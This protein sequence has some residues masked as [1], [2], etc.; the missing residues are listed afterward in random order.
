[1]PEDYP[2][3]LGPYVLLAPIGSGGMGEVWKARDTR[4]NRIVAIKRLKGQHASRF[5]QEARAIASLSHPNIC[6]LYDVGPDYLVMEYIEGK[7]VPGKLPQE[8]A[9]RFAIQIA[10]ALEEAHSRGILHR[11]LKPGNILISAKGSVKLLDFGLAKL[12]TEDDSDTTRTID[13]T[14]LGTA[15]YMSPEQAQGKRL[16][17]RSDVFSFGVV[18]YEMVSGTRAFSGD[19]LLETLNAVVRDEPAPLQSPAGDIVKRCMAKQPARRFQSIAEVRA[20][21]EQV[22]LKQE[23]RQPSIAVLPFANMSGD[24]EQEYFSEG[25]AEEII[26]ALT[27]VPGLKVIA[28][29]SAFA[30]KGKNEDIRRIAEALGV[31][32]ILEGSVRKAGNRIRVMA[33]LITAADG[34]HLWSER[35]DRDLT[36]IF[37]VQDEIAAA[38]AGAL[39]VTSTKST[40]L[41]RRRHAQASPAY[42]AYI[43]RARHYQWRTTPVSLARSKECYEQAIALDPKSALAYVDLATILRRVR[44]S[45][46]LD[47]RCRW[48]VRTP[49]KR[50]SLIPRCRKLTACRR[51]FGR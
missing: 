2:S 31:V 39:Q 37:A 6:V 7:P 5:E 49:R 47:R 1:M 44:I 24:K 51:E 10:S 46:R 26:N 38:I 22:L 9:I 36:D 4:L 14:V 41:Q 11:D 45:S 48:S 18:L 27:H 19:S 8:E 13:G 15:A 32:N 21:L 12:L 20:A 25:L 29:T 42:E 33:Q 3:Q 43:L 28:R 35:Y 34:S 16:D 40:A 30:F 23:E 17:E 50:W